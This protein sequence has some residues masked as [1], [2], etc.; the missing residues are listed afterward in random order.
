MTEPTFLGSNLNLVKE[1]NLRAVLLSL[2][3]EGSLSRIQLAQKTSLS[4]TTITNLVDE[5]HAQGVI[6]DS[7]ESNLVGRKVGRPRAGL[8]LV[9]DSR[10]AVGVQLRVGIFRVGITNLT[11]KLIERSEVEFSDDPPAEEVIGRIGDT[12]NALILRSG[13]EQSRI[14]GVGFG[15]TGL[16]NYS[17]GVNILAANFGWKD[18][19]IR[20]WLVEQLKLPVVVDNN[21]RCMA[22]G[23]AFFGVGRGVNSLAFIYARYGIG[24]GIVVNGKLYRG[25]GLGAGEIGHTI[26]LPH[27]GPMCR[28]G[29]RGCLE[30]L[31]AEPSLTRQAEQLAREHPGSILANNMA[32]SS[33]PRPIKRLFNA[34]RQGDP[35]ARQLIDTGSEY[36]GIALA[37]LVNLFTPELIL[38]GGLFEEEHEI[39]LP[40]ARAVMERTAFGGLGKQARLEVTSFGRQAGVIGAASLALA[41]F[42]YHN[43][44]DV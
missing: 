11:G 19:P 36:L 42:F 15:A 3:Y 7:G 28:C 4:A 6:R 14:V 9:D 25:S 20:E 39:I 31:A 1:H 40:T 38:L 18:V 10:Y 37:N 35:Y 43:S 13:I 2:L 21:V 5:L 27:D 41:K 32:D 17:T 24:A 34:Y 26:I 16:I 30:T 23:E 29:Q 22:L 33:V 44:V 12:I 8:R